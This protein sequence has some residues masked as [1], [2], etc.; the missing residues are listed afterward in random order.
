MTKYIIANL[1]PP[2][3]R[4]GNWDAQ[5][6]EWL[7]I[8][9]GKMIELEPREGQDC[10]TTAVSARAVLKRK[11]GHHLRVQQFQKR[12]YIINEAKP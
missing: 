7:R 1:P 9:P 3:S 4:T 10:H 8:P 5:F 6:E 2:R 11:Q 12:L